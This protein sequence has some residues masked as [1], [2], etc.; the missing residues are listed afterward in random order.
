[1]STSTVQRLQ[2]LRSFAL[3]RGIS[4]DLMRRVARREGVPG[5]A[6]Y[7]PR[8]F[9]YVTSPNLVE[10]YIATQSA[11]VSPRAVVSR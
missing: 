10:K 7:S 9:I 1:M 2:T 6:R 3:E 8:G 11:S 5:L 4:P